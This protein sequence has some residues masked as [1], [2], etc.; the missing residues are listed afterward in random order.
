MQDTFEIP[1]GFSDTLKIEGG[2]AD[3]HRTRIEVLVQALDSLQKTAYFLAAAKVDQSVG[4]RFKPSNAVKE[5]YAIQCGVPFGGSYALPLNDSPS[6][7][8]FKLDGESV[9]QRTYEAWACIANGNLADLTRLFPGKPLQ[10]RF[11]REI[12]RMIP[13]AGAP[14]KIGLQHKTQSSPIRITSKCAK[15]IK[16]WLTPAVQEDAVM[17]VT[18]ELVRIDFSK[19][20]VAIKYFPTQQEIECS[21]LP[22]IEDG[23]VESRSEPIQVTGRFTLDADGNPTKLT[24]V[25]RIEPLDLTAMRLQEVELGE[26]LLFIKEPL[27]LELTLEEE[28]RQYLEA[29]VP[30][31]D[32]FVYGLN[33]EI[34]LQEAE[35][36]IR[37]LWT[38]IAQA[39]PETL[40]EAAQQVRLVLLDRIEERTFHA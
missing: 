26:K 34:L 17:T 1:E 14:Y 28:N 20:I 5:Q 30:E 37:F 19:K 29:R 21:Y 11:L 25:N 12:Q 40:D 15:V 6:I 4:T 22:E 32:L 27:V 10:E 39:S 24:E 33:R 38:E 13:K 8:S 35:E 31:I 9:L 3:Q 16:D 36:S 23:I 7:P 18:G 2:E